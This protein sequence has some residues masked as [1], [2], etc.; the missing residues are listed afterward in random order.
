MFRMS[1]CSQKRISHNHMISIVVK[2][3][4]PFVMVELI[5]DGLWISFV[6]PLS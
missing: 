4:L 6:N 3:Q 5:L 1:P 2:A